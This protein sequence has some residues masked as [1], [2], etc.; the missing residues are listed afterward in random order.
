MATLTQTVQ[1]STTEILSEAIRH[2]GDKNLPTEL[3]VNGQVWDSGNFPIADA[4]TAATIWSATNGGLASFSYL[5][6]VADADM[7]LEI[8]NT[9]PN[10]DERALIFV[11]ANAML[12]LPSAYIG[13]YASNTS[14]LDGSA[15]VAATDYNAIGEIRVQ[16]NVAAGA[17]TTTCRLMLIK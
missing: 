9:T 6:F 7:W 15:L 3:T 13:G 8:A 10:P 16:N 4:Y 5:L 12:I 11:P 2:F 17:G 14:R 1:F